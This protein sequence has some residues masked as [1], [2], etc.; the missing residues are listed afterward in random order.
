MLEKIGQNIGKI[1]L[2]II[3]IAVFILGY[4]CGNNKNTSKTQLEAHTDTLIVHTT[5]TIFPKD[6]IVRFK[7]K[8][9]KGKIDTLYK[10]VYLDSGACNR[11]YVYNDSIKTKDYD[12]YSKAHVQGLFR[13]L[14]L[15]VRLKVPLRIY[16][17]TK[18]TIKDS[19]FITKSPKYQIYTGIIATPKMLA[20]TIDLSINKCTYSI[21]YDPFNKQP[22]I[23]F[24]YRLISWN[25][26]KKK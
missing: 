10:I 25:P 2:G 3:I 18:I 12:I 6:T 21:G 9:I 11:V 22:L 7:I 5:D 15:D 16:D 13:E 17:T 26:K 14:D 4:Q 23:G 19:I 24:K 1:F 20:P 8:P